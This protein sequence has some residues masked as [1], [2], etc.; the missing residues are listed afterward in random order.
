MAK[1]FEGADQLN[2][3]I[4]QED[5]NSFPH[6]DNYRKVADVGSGHASDIEALTTASSGSEV[7][8]ARD[9][10]ADLATAIRKGDEIGGDAV[11]ENVLND[12]LVKQSGTPDENVTIDTGDAIINGRKVRVASTQTATPVNFTAVSKERID[13]VHMGSSGTVGVT[14]GTEV[15][16][17]AGTAEAERPP[18]NTVILA[19]LF[20]R[21]GAANPSPFKPED[22][23]DTDNGTESFIIL[24]NERFFVQRDRTDAHRHPANL[25]L[26]GAFN[27]EETGVVE[28]WTA[29]NAIFARSTTQL[30]FGNNSGKITGDTSGPAGAVFVE[31]ELKAPESLRGKFLTVSGYMRLDSGTTGKT[32]RITIR[33]VG[34]TPESDFNTTLVLTDE[35]WQRFHIVGFIDNSVTQVF[36]RLEVDTTADNLIVGFLDGIQVS[37][38]RI[39]TEFEYPER[40]VKDDDGQL[41][42][43]GQTFTTPVTFSD[44]VTFNGTVS[45]NAN[46]TTGMTVEGNVVF[47]QDLTV[48]GD[49]LLKG[50]E[51]SESAVL[52][53]VG[54]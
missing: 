29:S 25:V 18:D 19:F 35:A 48:D 45:F 49:F 10:Q 41:L 53:W 7:S 15:T 47:Q 33:Q 14:T 12:F 26:N 5:I 39:L 21:S 38:G 8:A 22:I 34:D 51:D 28:G 2:E 13:V 43:A 54:L 17:G 52:A 23:R 46:I 3:I 31:Q 40:A 30:L 16:L 9:D 20:L 44:T 50:N 36:V 6:R 37:V 4:F 32:G 1:R 27:T 11:N 42:V 24:N